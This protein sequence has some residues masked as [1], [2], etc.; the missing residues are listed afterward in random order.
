MEALKIDLNDWE[1]TGGGMLGVSYF[2]KS[3]PNLMIK[4]DLRPK[5]MEAMQH[6]IEVSQNVYEL[7]VPTPKPGQV[8]FDGQR[9]GMMFTRIRNKVSYARALADNPENIDA[10]AK[11]YSDAVKQLHATQCDTQK[12]HSVKE[13]YR[14]YIGAYQHRDE[15]FKANALAVLESLPE[16]ST[17][18]HGDLHVGNIIKADGKSY[19]IDLGE[20]S[21]GHPYFDLSMIP[22]I[23][24]SW[25]GRDD[26]YNNAF[27]FGE[28]LFVEFWKHFVNYYFDGTKTVEQ[29]EEELLPYI[30]LRQLAME[31]L[32][33]R[34][35]E[36]E[37]VEKTFKIFTSESR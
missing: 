12:F 24:Y 6:E 8:V 17:C 36:G 32:S 35:K 9:Y 20:F 14:R 26:L 27:H 30:A 37:A 28:E 4:F 31:F 19:F 3:D 25:H 15:K 22:A 1:L 33:G 5:A 7:G 29:A 13:H 2:H 11:E 18:V 10:L 23:I 16:A 34:K 21:Y